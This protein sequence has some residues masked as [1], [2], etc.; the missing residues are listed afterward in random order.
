[1]TDLSFDPEANKLSLFHER[2]PIRDLWF[3]YFFTIV[4]FVMS[5]SS[6]VPES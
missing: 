5:Q 2:V 6:K 3:M 4:Y 1:M